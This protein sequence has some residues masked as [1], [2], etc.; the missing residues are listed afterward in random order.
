MSKKV[1]IVDDESDMRIFLTTL[2]ETNGFRPSCAADG[3]EGLE[4]ARKVK[5]ALII[6]DVMMP[7]ESGVSMYRELKLDA[8]LTIDACTDVS[9]KQRKGVVLLRTLK[10]RGWAVEYQVIDNGCGMDEDTRS[11]VF[12]RFFSTKGSQGTGLGLMIARKII[13]EHQGDIDFV[14]EKDRGTTFS[15]RL[16]KLKSRK[17]ENIGSHGT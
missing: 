13:G 11:K 4:M 12:Q 2:L 7:R 14:S 1:L 16:P 3:R 9:C 8:E 17:P 10:P 5:P 15:I 6:L